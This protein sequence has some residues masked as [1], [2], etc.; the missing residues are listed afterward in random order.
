MQLL[1]LVL[2]ASLG[3]L[4]VV[5]PDTGKPGGKTAQDDVVRYTED[6][7]SEEP[8]SNIYA[9]PDGDPLSIEIASTGIR[10]F[11]QKVGVDQHQ[12]VA[13]P[14][15]VHLAGWF[16]D[17]VLPGQ[18]GLSIIDG[19]VSGR[20]SDGVFKRLPEVNKGDEV[21]VTM[22][23]GQRFIYRVFATKTVPNDQA[24]AVLFDQNPSSVNGQLNLITCTG[25]FDRTTQTYADRVIVYA[26][27]QAEL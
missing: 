18:K 5:W 14:N 24:A 6:I 26:A 12:A 13:A 27:L 9:V 1:V 3:L 8:I 21:T 19:H 17:S 2:I 16:V 11:I 15:N 4:A 10:G 23:G 7:P 22:G 20:S 25:E